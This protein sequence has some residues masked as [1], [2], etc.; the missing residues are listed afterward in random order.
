MN[1]FCLFEIFDLNQ[2]ISITHSK[3]HVY[4]LKMFLLFFFILIFSNDFK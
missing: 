2:L 3:M 4:V 1:E